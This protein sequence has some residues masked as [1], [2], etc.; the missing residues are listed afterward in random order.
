VIPIQDEM[1]TG[2]EAQNPPYYQPKTRLA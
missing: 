2:C 1:A